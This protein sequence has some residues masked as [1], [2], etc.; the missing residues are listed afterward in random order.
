[1]F[2][3]NV[4]RQYLK[5]FSQVTSVKE[6]GCVRLYRPDAGISDKMSQ[7]GPLVPGAL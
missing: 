2:W 1:M 6:T 3:P 4:G 5:L 7:P